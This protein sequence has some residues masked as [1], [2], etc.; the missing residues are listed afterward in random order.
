MSWKASARHGV[1]EAPAGLAL[2]QELLNTRASMSYGPD[3][4]VLTPDDA[5][6]WLTD[7]LGTWSRVSSLPASDPA[8]LVDGHALAAPA[9]DHLRK[10]DPGRWPHLKHDGALPPADVPVSLVPDGDGWVRIVPGRPR[11]P[12]AGVR[13]VGRGAAGP[14]GGSRPR[15]KLCH[16]VDCRAA[17]FDTSRNNSGVW[18]DVSTC[19]NTANLR[20]FRERKRLMGGTGEQQPPRPTCSAPTCDNFPSAPGTRTPPAATIPPMACERW[21]EMLSA[22]MDGEDDP[23]DRPLVDEHLAGC[24]GRR[25]WLDRAATVNRLTRTGVVTS[26]PGPERGDP[27]R[28]S[29]RAAQKAHHQGP[30]ICRTGRHRRGAAH[31]RADPGRRRRVRRARAHRPRRD[32]RTPVARVGGLER[33]GGRRIPLHRAAPEPAVRPGADAHRLRRDAAVALRQRPSRPPGST[34]PG[35]SATAS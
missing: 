6:R 19:G 14:A 27:G 8:A 12:M 15:L 22:Q 30:A 5:Q 33:G 17:F 2:V 21:R 7:A 10:R 34:P 31:P 3:L 23:A 26:V 11:H 4:L 16:N 18:H 24:A 13:V 32:P 20:A 29:L 1:R 9:S 25:Q 28:R 35:W